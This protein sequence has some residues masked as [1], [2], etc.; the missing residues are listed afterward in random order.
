MPVRM[1]S[2]AVLLSAGLEQ[3][4]TKAS[5]TALTNNIAKMA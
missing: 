1:S 4:P 5:A 2:R 3:R